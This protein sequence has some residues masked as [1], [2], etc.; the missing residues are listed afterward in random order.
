VR[1]PSW[2][3]PIGQPVTDVDH[4]QQP[5]VITLSYAD[6]DL[7]AEEVEADTIALAR[8]GFEVWKVERAQPVG[9]ASRLRALLHD[10][11]MLAD[12]VSSVVDLGRKGDRYRSARRLTVSFRRTDP[13]LDR[14]STSSHRAG[15]R[16]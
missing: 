2:F 11:G 8:H 14:A 9:M 1:I 15:R 3:Q 5:N 10:A 4:V 13:Q 7:S 12:A 16:R 6:D